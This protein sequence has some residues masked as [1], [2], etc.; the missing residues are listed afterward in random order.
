MGGLRRCSYPTEVDKG[1]SEPSHSLYNPLHY[2]TTNYHSREG[3]ERKKKK[4]SGQ[5]LHNM[6]SIKSTEADWD[7]GGC[8]G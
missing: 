3:D 6:L 4:K 7:E 1:I 5:F 8:G 2:P